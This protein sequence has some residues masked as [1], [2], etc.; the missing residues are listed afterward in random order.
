MPNREPT[1]S[2]RDVQPKHV[3][4]EEKEPEKYLKIYFEAAA[5]RARR[6]EL[7]DY[8]LSLAER[9]REKQAK[10]SGPEFE[11]PGF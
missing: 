11:E 10:R 5:E 9:K 8:E 1:F 7:T 3:W 2:I 6:G 4:P